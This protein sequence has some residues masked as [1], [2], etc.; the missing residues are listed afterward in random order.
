MLGRWPAS[1]AI[2]TPALDPAARQEEG[3]RPPFFLL[4]IAAL[5][6]LAWAQVVA[7]RPAIPAVDPTGWTPS[8]SPF[9]ARILH[10]GSALTQAPGQGCTEIPETLWVGGVV[11]PQPPI[12][13]GGGPTISQLLLPVFPEYQKF[14]FKIFLQHRMKIFPWVATWWSEG[15]VI[16]STRPSHSALPSGNCHVMHE[17][18]FWSPVPANL[19][20]REVILADLSPEGW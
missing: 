14:L 1:G 2:P 13:V 20:H 3:P 11:D 5:L 17:T 16:P 19:S 9:L 18:C 4:R 15:G 10:T 6:A 8:P 12:L 7:S